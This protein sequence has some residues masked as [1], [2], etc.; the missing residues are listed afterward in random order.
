MRVRVT[1]A[2]AIAAATLASSPLRAETDDRYPPAETARVHSRHRAHPRPAH[3]RG[4]G[5]ADLVTVQTA[6]GIPIRVAAD[7][8]GRFAG[9]I[10][11]LVSRGIVPRTIHCYARG[12]H[13]RNSR[14][15]TGRAC[16]FDG[17]ANKWEPMRRGRVTELAAK[18]GLHDGC[19]YRLRRGVADCGHID[20][21]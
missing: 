9:F 13:V 11:D 1:V 6:A 4:R 3:D 10:S 8:A 12:G 15:Y 5:G 20:A 16:D 19:S 2:L 17:S 18:W 21:P 14:H 7:V